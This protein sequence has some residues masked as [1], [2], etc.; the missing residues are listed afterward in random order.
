MQ[1][2]DRKSLTEITYDDIRNYHNELFHLKHISR[3][4]EEST[5]HQFLKYLYENGKAGIGK[6]L[7]MYVL[8]KGGNAEL[9]TLPEAER[10]RIEE[11]R[12]ESL[13][14]PDRKSVV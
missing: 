1:S 5:L 11:I 3:V 10:K 14:F 4:I 7:Y 6:Y 9:D 2:W 13:A 8:E 12:Q